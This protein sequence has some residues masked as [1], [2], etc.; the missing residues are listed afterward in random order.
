MLYPLGRRVFRS[1]CSTAPAAPSKPGSALTCCPANPLQVNLTPGNAHYLSWVARPILNIADR[2]F[3]TVIDW[4]VSNTTGATRRFNG[5]D[6]IATNGG[7]ALETIHDGFAFSVANNCDGAVP[8][9][10]V[11]ARQQPDRKRAQQG[12]GFHA[13]DPPAR[14]PRRDHRIHYRRAALARLQRQYHPRRPLPGGDRAGLA[15]A[16]SH[17]S[18]IYPADQPH[19]Q[20]GGK[21]LEDDWRH[22]ALGSIDNGEADDL[23]QHASVNNDGLDLF[24]IRDYTGGTGASFEPGDC[25]KGGTT[26]AW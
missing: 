24:I 3:T 13:E 5:I 8:H 26:T 14:R 2:S 6:W 7:S 1:A 10:A 9:H 25:T 17:G 12:L 19:C 4:T 11:F 23:F 20:P 16:A 21:Q 18:S 22:R 15:Q